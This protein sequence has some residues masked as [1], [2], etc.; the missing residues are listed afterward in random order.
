[1]VQ[2]VQKLKTNQ[3]WML[4]KV[5]LKPKRSKRHFL[6]KLKNMKCQLQKMQSHA[7]LVLILENLLKIRKKKLKKIAT[8]M[9]L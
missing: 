7:L 6:K 2:I 4:R 3:K 9:K 8:K 1:M 5:K